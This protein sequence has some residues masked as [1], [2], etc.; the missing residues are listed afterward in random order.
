MVCVCVCVCV[1]CV[2]VC[3]CVCIYGSVS[4]CDVNMAFRTKPGVFLYLSLSFSLFPSLPHLV[5]PALP[6]PL[7]SLNHWHT[8]GTVPVSVPR[9]SSTGSASRQAHTHSTPH[10]AHRTPHTARSTLQICVTH[11]L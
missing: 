8:A 9:G 11:K 4:A 7:F 3:V 5:S 2:C 10:T 6:V 1:R